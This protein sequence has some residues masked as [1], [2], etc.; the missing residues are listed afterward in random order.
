MTTIHRSIRRI[1]FSCSMTHAGRVHYITPDDVRILLSR[2]PAKLWERLR[3][4]H[5]NDRS[6]GK[7]VLGYVNMGHREI[8]ICAIPASV[9]CSSAIPRKQRCS[10]ATFGALRGRQWPQL[11][12]RRFLLYDVFLHELGHLQIIDPT[13]TNVRRRFA[14]ETLAQEFANTW[15]RAMWAQHFDHPDPVHNPPTLDELQAASKEERMVQHDLA[16]TL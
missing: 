12:V 6:R 1:K 15:R 11:A 3:G 10:P 5:F 2:L 7:R 8:A 4:V 13:A 14:S 16:I 9:S